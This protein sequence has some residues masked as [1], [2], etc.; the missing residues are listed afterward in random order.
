MPGARP[1]GPRG[2]RQSGGAGGD[3]GLGG[4][5]AAAGEE[6]EPVAVGGQLDQASRRASSP[7]SED[8]TAVPFRMR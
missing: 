5:E 3:P 1:V 4:G 6:G 8:G 2:C 7:R